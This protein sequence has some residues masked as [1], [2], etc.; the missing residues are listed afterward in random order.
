MKTLIVIPQYYKIRGRYYQMPLGLAYINAALREAKLDVECLNM[1]HIEAEDRYAV[2]ADR[3]VNGQIDCVLCG[4][5]SPIWKTIKKVFDTVKAVKPSV[6]TVGGGG[7][8]TSEP[9]VAS[10]LI[11]VDY[12]V[13]GEGEITD[14]EL[15]QTLENKGDVSHVEGIVYKMQG[16]GYLQTPPREQITDIDSIPFPCYEGFDMELWLDN[17]RVSNEYF[18]AYSDKPRMMPMILGRSCPF[19]C[20][21]CFHPTGNRYVVRSLDN[22]FQE[23][24]IWKQ[25]YAP[26]CILVLDE[27]FSSSV[28]RVYEFCERIKTYDV[29]WIVQ[30]RV[31]IITSELLHTMHDAGCISISYGLESFSPTVLKNMRKHIATED[32]E[33]ALKLTYEAGIDIQGNFIFG[34]ELEDEHTIYET[35]TFWFAHQEYHIYL[36][37]IETYPG[38]GYYQDLM[39]GKGRE[40]KKDFL[41]KEVYITNLT[42]MSDEVYEKYRTLF[43]LLNFYYGPQDFPGKKIYLNEAGE[44]VV[45]VTCSHC[46]EKNRWSGVEKHIMENTYFL[47]RCRSCNQRNLIYNR[48]ERLKEWDKIKHLCDMVAMAENEQ[49]FKE[50]VDILYR[51]YMEV[52]DPEKPFPI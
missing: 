52:R 8:F 23:L 50:A 15:L 41:E 29:K 16:G 25:K 37:M 20:K 45:E 2:L 18:A 13:I 51:V 42:K 1:N 40:E 11:G 32:I 9:L 5:I 21:F 49:D 46:G 26:T 47:L 30:M 6:I 24:D 31:D 14:V 19:Q 7:C 33:R 35:L 36:G 22:F 12:A 3:V 44:G 43:A 38:S 4:G 27:L 48:K 39:K 34:D 28:E 10:E 17:Q